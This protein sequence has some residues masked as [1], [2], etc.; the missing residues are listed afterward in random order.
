MRALLVVGV[1]A[2]DQT[3]FK[4]APF[5][6]ALTR[7]YRIARQRTEPAIRQPIPKTSIHLPPSVCHFCQAIDAAPP[8]I[9]SI[10]KRLR[11]G[12]SLHSARSTSQLYPLAHLKEHEK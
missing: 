10:F 8:V 6:N 1:D 3:Y 9:G 7:T 5:Y 11:M 4:R 12:S 2:N